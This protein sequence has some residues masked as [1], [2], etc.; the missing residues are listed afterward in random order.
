MLKA[1][2]TH[3]VTYRERLQTEMQFQ[4]LSLKCSNFSRLSR[5]KESIR[6]I[7]KKHTLRKRKTKDVTSHILRDECLKES[8]NL[9]G[10]LLRVQKD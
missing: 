9:Y 6:K 5:G 8:G 1:R 3:E 7:K 4:D 10:M 2:R